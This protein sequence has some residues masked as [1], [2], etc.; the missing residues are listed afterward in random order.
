MA[1]G[2]GDHRT[3]CGSQER[4]RLFI[5]SRCER[6]NTNILA[7]LAS[8]LKSNSEES[9]R[10]SRMER[11]L[12]LRLYRN[13]SPQPIATSANT[14]VEIFDDQLR[15]QDCTT[16]QFYACKRP[17]ASPLLCDTDAGW[18]N[19]NGMCY[20]YFS[21]LR[22][23][24]DARGDCNRDNAMLISARNVQQETI[25]LN[26]LESRKT[27]I[28]IG[29]HT[30]I[31]AQGGYSWMWQDGSMF[32]EAQY[33]AMD[34]QENDQTRNHTCIAANTTRVPPNIWQVTDCSSRASFVCQKAE[35][36]CALGWL[37]H[38]STCYEVNNGRQL[39]W[40]QAADFCTGQGASLVTIQSDSEQ[41]F[42]ASNLQALS[43]DG[44]GSIWIG[45]TDNGQGNGLWFTPNGTLS[46][47]KKYFVP[48][49]N[50]TPSV[51]DCVTIFTDDAQGR[52]Q[53]S[54]C[55]VPRAFICQ[56]PEG[57]TPTPMPTLSPQVATTLAMSANCGQFWIE[58][59]VTAHCYQLI[60][61]PVTWFVASRDCVSRGGQLACIDSLEE[62][63]FI[64]NHLTGFKSPGLWIGATNLNV[65]SGFQWIDGNGFAFIN[66]A[67]GE[68]N[69]VNNNEH[70]G[71]MITGGPLRSKWNDINCENQRGYICEKTWGT[72]TMTVT[73][74]QPPPGQV[75]G[76]PND[77]MAYGDSCY[78]F[79]QMVSTW[80]D[81]L[82]YCRQNGLE[83]ASIRDENEQNF[84]Y[85]QL[86]AGSGLE[87][88][89]QYWVGLNDMQIQMTFQWTDNSPVSY[90]NW[91]NGEPNNW[92]SRREDCVT[93]YQT[94][95]TWND[96]KCD[97]QRNGFVCKTK[98]TVMPASSSTAQPTGC[99][100]PGSKPYGYYCYVA[101][102]SRAGTQ[103]DAESFCRSQ[104]TGGGLA[105]ISDSHQQAFLAS[106]LSSLTGTYW[107]GLKDRSNNGTYTW[108]SG[109]SLTYTAWNFNHTGNERGTCVSL[110]TRKPVG[111][112]LNIPC[113]TQN[114]FLCQT[115]RQGFSTL[116][117]STVTAPSMAS[118]PSDWRDNQGYCYKGFTNIKL[119][120]FDA[121]NYCRNLG[122]E[123]ISLHSRQE[124]NFAF[125]YFMFGFSYTSSYWIG[126]NDFDQEHGHRWSD[127]SPVDYTNWNRGEPNDATGD[128]DCVEYNTNVRN[129]NDNN[130]Y[131]AKGFMCK[132]QKGKQIR[133]TTAPPVSPT[134][135][136]M[137]GSGSDWTYFNGSCYWFS[138]KYGI[139]SKLSW[140][141]ART[142]CMQDGADLVVIHSERENG[143]LINMLTMKADTNSWI[144][145]E[146]VHQ[147]SF[148]WVDGS[149]VDYVK[150]M[151]N[152]PNNAYGAEKCASLLSFNGYWNDDDCNDDRGFIC[153][154]PNGTTMARTVPPTPIT[155]GGCPPNYT[156][157][158]NNNKCF[159][160]GGL[161]SG[162]RANY[163]SA[164]QKCDATGGEIAAINS[165]QEQA[166][167]I[168]MIQSYDFGFWIGFNDLNHDGHYG[169]Q[170]N[171]EVTLTNWDRGQPSGST[172]YLAGRDNC[173]QMR[174]DTRRVGK[175][176]NIQ[177]SQAKAYVCQ[178]FHSTAYPASSPPQS[179]CKQGYTMYGSSCFRVNKM[180]LTWNNAQATCAGDGGNLASL[181]SV[182]EAA[183][184]DVITSDISTPIWIGLSDSKVR[185]TYSWA[186]GWALRYTKWAKDEPTM[187]TNDGCVAM[188]G[189][190]WNDTVCDTVYPSLC[191][192][193]YFQPPSTTP[194]SGGYCADKSW[195]LF[196]DN[197]Y[198]IVA[199]QSMSWPYANYLCSRRGM[200]L[201]S[202]HSYEENLFILNMLD[203][204]LGP[205]PMNIWIGFNKGMSGYLE[206]TDGSSVTYIDWADGQP[207]DLANKN[208]EDCV[209]LQFSSGKWNDDRC[210]Q[211]KGYICKVHKIIPST[212]PSLTSASVRIAS[213]SSAPTSSASPTS[214]SSKSRTVSSSTS[215]NSI[216]NTVPWLSASTP[217]STSQQTVSSTRLPQTTYFLP[218]TAQHQVQ[219][220]KSSDKRLSPSSI[221]GILVGIMA[222]LAFA[223]AILLVL[224]KK[225]GFFHNT[226]D[227]S[228]DNPMY[229]KSND[230]VD[231]TNSSAK[232]NGGAI[233][234]AGHYDDINI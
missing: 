122:A 158:Y 177:C 227:Q 129:W 120:W 136:V 102:S 219:V 92:N 111:V 232:E 85:S 35:G 44:I 79:K 7:P 218:P 214:L 229:S 26:F 103:A 222:C 168:T 148:G 105:E 3:H 95:G 204:M 119:S 157:M 29:L 15:Y 155:Q 217:L 32:S 28:W 151:S 211:N 11:V 23:W 25:L 46:Q 41:L 169:W 139:G 207:S 55:S 182:Y 191:K 201:A 118:C 142:H 141:Q 109:N 27:D 197:C 147:G 198:M 68:P 205:A 33:G 156:P 196:G 80:N 226:A 72:T 16:Q 184:V 47:G 188:Q 206:W 62:Q 34:F 178:A 43:Q 59:A 40:R 172:F 9:T 2:Q 173:V 228:F 38:Q 75:Y 189:S 71:E 223:C 101:I 18:E 215:S 132:I 36:V 87:Y 97:D 88:M 154:K 174:S 54:N 131:I 127:G 58:D 57:V 39:A 133:T 65:R 143:F 126:F 125:S 117:R 152:E 134:P 195:H 171:S 1:S 84:V 233:Q 82:S 22:T 13:F 230:S 81:A 56:I 121:N 150:W 124:E 4:I 48:N 14:C 73:H 199:N 208:Q 224:K 138:P 70:C 170:D 50:N 74:A 115:L 114:H 113:N 60:D 181:L 63:T 37:Q 89:N 24:D 231:I 216:I 64:T 149:P 209:E 190:N 194:L 98:Q 77:Q 104:G 8:M 100:I 123:L 183:Y 91:R 107:I 52:W 200:T 66:W 212:I 45:Y 153:K 135:H 160:L 19:I 180:P 193:S 167:L 234:N 53:L 67:P 185:G 187:G 175:W 12:W 20:K 116:P 21:L 202:I 137:C 203:S 99:S 110:S 51:Q 5:R 165:Y 145:F 161:P 6:I 225:Y 78:L 61:N 128:D 210:M 86:Q 213:T 76:C 159:Y 179:I 140:Y 130:C 31:Q 10:R 106:Q 69:N 90:T 112:W 164:I 146:A 94:D 162:N 17:K 83:L 96:E 220:I 186:D 166:F 192:I 176:E 42:V 30:Y 221:A 108:E 93:I 163:T 144:G 49:V